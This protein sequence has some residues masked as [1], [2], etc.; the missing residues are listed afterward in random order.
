M[1]INSVIT[2]PSPGDI[3]QNTAGSH[4]A[5]VDRALATAALFWAAVAPLMQFLLVGANS[6]GPARFTIVVLAFGVHATTCVLA[7]LGRVPP[8]ALLVTWALIGVSVAAQATDGATELLRAA[9]NVGISVSILAGLLLGLR[10]A[11]T[12]SLAMSVA[13]ALALAAAVPELTSNVW[14]YLVLLPLNSV[15]SACA[16][17]LAVRELRSVAGVADQRAHARFTAD[18]TLARKMAEAEAGRRRARLLH[19][20]VVNTLGAIA[21]G[22]IISDDNV[23]AQRC[24]DDVRAV[25]ELRTKRGATWSS[26]DDVYVHARTMG[27][28]VD[29]DDIDGL[30]RLLADRPTWQLREVLSTIRE[31]VTNIAKHAQVSA[32]R[33]EFSPQRRRISVIDDGAGM[34]DVGPVQSSMAIRAEDAGVRTAIIST[35]G[36]GTTAAIELP[37]P[38]QISRSHVFER[39]SLRMATSIS[40]VMVAQFAAVIVVTTTFRTGW[41]VAAVV[42]AL[43]VWLIVTGAL[44]AMLRHAAPTVGLPPAAVLSGY[45]ALAGGLVVF[46]LFRPAQS[47]C[48][49]HPNLGWTGDAAAAICAVLVLLDGRFR[50]VGP[51]LAIIVVGS[52]VVLAE[53]AGRCGGSTVALLVADALVVAA[54]VILRRQVRTLSDAAATQIDDEMHRREQQE[55]L[56]AEIAIRS[57]GFDRLMDDARGLLDSV[58]E[59]PSSVHEPDVRASA[60]LE[61]SYLRA[62]IGLPYESGEITEAFVRIVEAAKR[63]RVRIE[64]NLEEG[65]LDTVAARWISTLAVSIIATCEP[66]EAVSLGIF[67]S[68]GRREL[69][70]VAPRVRLAHP[71]G[72]IEIRW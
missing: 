68:A 41:S 45:L 8:A 4:R 51:A 14:S 16:A 12:S 66:D 59:R 26:I 52:F 56:A 25:D 67:R 31:A 38:Q 57:A 27:V 55:R 36:E 17:G 53:D 49:V 35:P 30:R 24:A 63:A 22:R 58:A 2:Q 47:A 54:F 65:A 50:V 20:T 40:T 48:G 7:R 64:I 11:L 5:G 60:A 34:S 62:L 19:D 61:E 9:L 32:A 3:S 69:I 46:G 28:T 43:T 18:R 42:P 6:H 72:L 1:S 70:L 29:I 37:A 10:A 71:D 13:I 21:T 23:I 15:A 44:A 33:I 39:A